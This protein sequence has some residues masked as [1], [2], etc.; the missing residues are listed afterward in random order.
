MEAYACRDGLILAKKLRVNRSHLETDCQELVS[1]RG[2]RDGGRS[3]ITLIIMEICE[4][5]LCFQ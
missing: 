3:V 1:L 5:R 4:L 2:A